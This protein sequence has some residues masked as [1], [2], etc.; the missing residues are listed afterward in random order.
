MPVATKLQM[1][2]CKSA[3][4]SPA[5]ARGESHRRRIGNP[6]FHRLDRIHCMQVLEANR[7]YAET[8]F[9]RRLTAANPAIA[10]NAA[11]AII[12]HDASAGVGATAAAA[13]MVTLSFASL[14]AVVEAALPG[15]PL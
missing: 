9:A 5:C 1:R 15:S 13:A 4:G 3:D 11:N 8:Y 6:V 10:S 2:V 7:Y 14:Q 12:I